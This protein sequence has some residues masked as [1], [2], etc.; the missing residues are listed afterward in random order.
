MG[1][2]LP[3]ISNQRR[4]A[5]RWL[6]R[7][8]TIKHNW[9]DQRECIPFIREIEKKLPKLKINQTQLIKCGFDHIVLIINGQ[10]VFRFPRNEKY[11]AKLLVEHRVLG[12]LPKHCG[13][14]VPRY[15]FVDAKGLFGCYSLI[16]GH[17][18]RPEI[19]QRL[20]RNEQKAI[21]LALS[22]FLNSLHTLRTSLVDTEEGMNGRAWEDQRFSN[23]E[24][25]IRKQHISTAIEADTF[26]KLER[27]FARYG[28]PGR[29]HITSCVVHGDMVSNHVLLSQ[30]RNVGV[31]D[32]SELTVGDPAWDLAVIG[33]YTDWATSFLVERSPYANE[34]K[35]LLARCHRQAVRYWTERLY[36][37]IE[38]RYTDDCL[39]AI[40][41]MLQASLRRTET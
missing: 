30:D 28:R 34:D 26:S 21:L 29:E 41:D 10:K 36:W 12:E 5:S 4:T 32:F 3:E 35:T 22:A 19:F 2:I 11:R 27:F 15:D 24:F 16:P 18:L 7:L 38:G 14:A 39:E 20:D 13:V 8:R 1:A 37:K 33:S 25:E 6:D 9:D 40:I 23:G 17:E 31:I